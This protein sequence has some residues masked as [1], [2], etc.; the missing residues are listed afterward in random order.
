MASSR[1]RGFPPS[2]NG[3]S[4]MHA[5]W[6]G[7]PPRILALSVELTIVD[8]PTTADLYFWA[9][10]ASFLDQGRHGG[11]GHLGLQ[12]YQAHPGSTAVNWG[13]YGPDGKILSGSD[14][15]LPTTPGNANTRDYEWSANRTYRLTIEG[16]EAG[17]LGSITD[18]TDDTTTVVREL[19]AP[20]MHLG[21][22]VMW[23]EVFARC[24]GPRVTIQWSNPTVTSEDGPLD[25]TS[26]GL[27]YQEYS[28]GGCTNTST[29]IRDGAIVQST[30]TPRIE[31]HGSTLSF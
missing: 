15:S 18:L 26:F 29:E 3:A 21:D 5:R 27:S 4:S 6:L 17:W 14:S 30:A 10:Q 1:E 7:L 16:R 13:G 11:A 19:Y 9:V 20:G 12:H 8:P 2:A 22:I 28:D 23:S 25:I 24:E 31:P